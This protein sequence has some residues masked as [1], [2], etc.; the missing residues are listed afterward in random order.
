MKRAVAWNR[1]R[2]EYVRSGKYFF[3]FLASCG[4]VLLV[5]ASKKFRTA[6]ALGLPVVPEVYMRNDTSSSAPF[7]QGASALGLGRLF[8]FTTEIPEAVGDGM[9]WKDEKLIE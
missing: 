2:A 7:A 9:S 1:G 4:R 5:A 3:G 6:Q 8:R